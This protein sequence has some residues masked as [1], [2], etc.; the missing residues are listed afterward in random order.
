MLLNITRLFAALALGALLP[1]TSSG[2]IVPGA[3]QPDWDRARH[4]YT[5]GV[6]RSY[7]DVMGKWRAA[8]LEGDVAA[9][10]ELYDEGAVLM[11][12]D[13]VPR[14]GRAAI[15]LYVRSILP[16]TRELRTG[17]SD[18]VASERLAYA[19]APIYIEVAEGTAV[20]AYSG[21]AVTI[22]VRDGRRWKIRSQILRH[23]AL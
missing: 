5:A 21:S 13:S 12:D 1:A 23:Q 20:R 10:M 17:L 22:L 8:W 2:Q 4:E 3:P 14:E 7:N 19:L 9:V 6:L 18:F 11:V 16:R 15:E